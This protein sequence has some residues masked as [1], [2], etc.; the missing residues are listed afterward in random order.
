MSTFSRLA[1]CALLILMPMYGWGAECTTVPVDGKSDLAV[2]SPDQEYLGYV[3]QEV[4]GTWFAWREGE[5]TTDKTHRTYQDAVAWVCERH[6]DTDTDQS[7][8]SSHKSGKFGH[9]GI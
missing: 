1:R 9:S 4:D 2:Y 5:G 3:A 6:L 8:N 7:R